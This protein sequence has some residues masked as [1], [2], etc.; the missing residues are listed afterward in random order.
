LVAPDDGTVFTGKSSI[1][2]LEWSP[3]GNLGPNDYYIVILQFQE[4][5]DV[6]FDGARRKETFWDLDQRFFD[7]VDASNPEFKWRVVVSH[8]TTDAAG[9]EVATEV[10]PPSEIRSFI[11][12][13]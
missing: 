3:V 2:R 7:R 5:G 6:V 10:S 9:N 1:P 13:E 8:I 11:W 12:R 4:K